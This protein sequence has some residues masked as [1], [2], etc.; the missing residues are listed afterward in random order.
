M[1][2]TKGGGQVTFWSFPFQ[3][4]EWIKVNFL[5]RPV[6]D[7]HFDISKDSMKLGKTF[8][9]VA[10][11]ADDILG[12]SYQLMGWGLYEKFDKGIALMRQW[13]EN[14]KIGDAVS[15]EA[16]SF[17]TGGRYSLFNSLGDVPCELEPAKC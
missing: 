5:E 2:W 11:S 17:E 10:K 7:D 15:R 3:E 14:G 1:E 9:M 8:A 13:L 12:R 4:L 16:V 6:Y